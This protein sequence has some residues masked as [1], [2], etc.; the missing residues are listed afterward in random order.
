MELKEKIKEFAEKNCFHFVYGTLQYANLVGLA[1][2]ER[3]LQVDPIEVEDI[4]NRGGQ[5]ETVEKTNIALLVPSTDGSEQVRPEQI[6]EYKYDNYIHSLKVTA[7]H[8]ASHL[9]RCGGFEVRTFRII[10]LSGVLDANTDGILLQLT[11][12]PYEV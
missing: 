9:S 7:R 8:L 1:A 2:N 4:F 3:I 6:Y 5:I 11:V 10:E 12:K